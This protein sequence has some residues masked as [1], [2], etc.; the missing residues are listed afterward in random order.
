MG[1]GKV[2]V[3][4][5]PGGTDASGTVSKDEGGESQAGSQHHAA[6]AERAGDQAPLSGIHFQHQ[7]P[8]LTLLGSWGR[9]LRPVTESLALPCGGPGRGDR[10]WPTASRMPA[11]WLHFGFGSQDGM[12][13]SVLLVSPG[14]GRSPHGLLRACQQGCLRLQGCWCSKGRRPW[15]GWSGCRAPGSHGH[16]LT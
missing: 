5:P 15:S 2:Q 7:L 6:G 13:P 12:Q 11:R 8:T 9:V 4:V 14:A 3:G 10:V 1:R 16:F